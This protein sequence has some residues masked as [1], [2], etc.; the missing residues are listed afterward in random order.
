LKCFWEKITTNAFKNFSIG[1]ESE[2]IN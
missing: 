2:A 1:V